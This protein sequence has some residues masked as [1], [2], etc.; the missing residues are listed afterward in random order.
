MIELI[1]D[2]FKTD[3][4][5][6]DFNGINMYGDDTYQ[7]PIWIRPKSLMSLG[8]LGDKIQ[9]MGHTSMK[10]TLLDQKYF[11]VDTLQ[12]GIYLMNEDGEFKKG[13]IKTE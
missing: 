6:F 11:F 7:T 12:V 13:E 9:I 5:K 1:N 2:L 10:D 8:Q 3:Q 4:D